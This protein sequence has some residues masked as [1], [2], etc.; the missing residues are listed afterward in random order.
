MTSRCKNELS[1][2]ISVKLVSPN[3]VHVWQEHTEL[4]KAVEVKT[5]V[6]HVH[7]V[8]IAKKVLILNL[9]KV[10]IFVT[11]EHLS[12][13]QLITLLVISVHL[14]TFVLSERCWRNH[15]HPEH[16]VMMKVWKSAQNFVK[17]DFTVLLDLSRVMK[18]YVFLATT[19]SRDQQ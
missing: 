7:Q 9:V 6:Q 8:N 16:M 3:Q 13:I 18:N 1:K 15:V 11:M 19:V 10:V 5:R 17:K 12:L 2:T 14:V 4:K